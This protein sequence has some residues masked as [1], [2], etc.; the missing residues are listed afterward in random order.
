ML[1]LALTARWIAALIFCLSLAAGF[2]LLAQWQVGRTILENS[3]NETWSK[4]EVVELASIAKPNSPFT[5]SEIS[6]LGDQTVLTKVRTEFT[7]DV[8]NAVLISNRIQVNGDRG[9]WVVVPAQTNSAKLFVVTGFIESVEQ[10]QMALDKIRKLVVVQ[11][12]VP[13]TGRYLPSEAPLE[14]VE[15]DIYESLSVSQLINRES[16]E[17]S[18]VYTGF[19]A[20]TEENVLSSVEGVELV[21]I[22]MPQS[23]SQVNWLSAFY[24]IEWTVFAGFAVFMWWRLLADAYKKQQVALLAQ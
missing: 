18:S 10:A 23:D 11:A 13:H 7:L 22:G 9:F 1:K 21:T 16:F 19:M 15:A 17:A 2:S 24:A 4:V 3:S 5:F 14:S 8:A 6:I 12:L 20:L